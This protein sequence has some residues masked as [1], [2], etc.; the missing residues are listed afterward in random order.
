MRTLTDTTQISTGQYEWRATRAASVMRGAVIG[1]IYQKALRL[2]VTASDVSPEGALTLASTDVETAMQGVIYYHDVWGA[3]LEMGIGTY[4]LYRQL[5]PACAM[6]LAIVLVVLVASAFVAVPIGKAQAAWI[7]ASQDRVTT[8]SK[9]LASIKPLKISGLSSLAFSAV[10]DLRATELRVSEKFRKLLAATLILMICIPIWSPILTFCVFAGQAGNVLD[11]QKAFTSYALLALV[12]RPLTEVVLALPVI[13]SSVTS[14]GRIQKFLNGR[15]RRD[16]RVTGREEHENSG[17]GLLE[18]GIIAS[19]Q[20]TF[21]WKEDAEPLLDIHGWNI[22]AKTFTLLLGPVGCGK[23]TLLKALLGELSDFE[24]TIRT[25]YSRVGYCSQNAWLPNDT[26]R[27][28]IVGGATF[29]GP[30]YARVLE[31]CALDPDV[32]EWPTGDET[33]VGTMGIAMSG[34]QRHRL[35]RL[36]DRP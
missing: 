15:E 9:T 31:A 35:V 1:L 12:N 28:I 2:D 13:A 36:F 3:F 29:D 8:T 4:L 33:L 23:S 11:F 22:R 17:K 16:N 27:N 14:F 24:G 30:W 20:G 32:Q 25:N 7:Q 19:V 5:G 18:K 6:P 21:G 34:G 10:R 26:V